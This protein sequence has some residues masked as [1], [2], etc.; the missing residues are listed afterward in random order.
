[1]GCIR[2]YDGDMN[3]LKRLNEFKKY[4]ESKI[5]NNATHHNSIQMNKEIQEE[6]QRISQFIESNS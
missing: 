6:L 5:I 2:C 4:L 3:D 1:M